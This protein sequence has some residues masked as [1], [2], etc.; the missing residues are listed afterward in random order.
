MRQVV[1]A[2]ATTGMTPKDGARIS[3]LA[4]LEI[5]GGQPT[6][7]T[8]AMTFKTDAG[9]DGITFAEQFDALDVFIGDVPVVVFNATIWRRFL[10]AELRHIRKRGARRL[11]TQFIDLSQQARQRFPKQRKDLAA[12]AR[13]LGVNVNSDEVGI[14]RDAALL[15]GIAAKI[16]SPYNPV[17]SKPRASIEVSP[18]QPIVDAASVMPRSFGKRLALCWRVLIGQ[19]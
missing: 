18:S 10:R 15:A 19:A 4:A 17:I 7:R 13:K 14:A 5:V 8:L 1:I 16:A 3:E 6:A 12:L 9:R 2:F 11:L